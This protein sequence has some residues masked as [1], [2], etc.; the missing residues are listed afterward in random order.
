MFQKSQSFF[1]HRPFRVFVGIYFIRYTDLIKLITIYVDLQTKTKIFMF[2]TI[3][4]SWHATVPIPTI[5]EH[6]LF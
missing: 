4:S 5:K 2:G 3:V 6:K 1:K